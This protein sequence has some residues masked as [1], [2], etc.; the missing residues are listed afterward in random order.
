MFLGDTLRSFMSL[1]MGAFEEASGYVFAFQKANLLNKNTSGNILTTSQIQIHCPVVCTV[2][3]KT[4]AFYTI[5][6]RKYAGMP[7]PVGG[8]IHDK[9]ASL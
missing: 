9:T 6:L 7:H 2:H 1:C 8:V 5:V 4:K 3:A